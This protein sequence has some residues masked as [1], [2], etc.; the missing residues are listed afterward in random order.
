MNLLEDT[1]LN[2]NGNGTGM[3][4]GYYGFQRASA[5]ISYVY[6]SNSYIGARNLSYIGPAVNALGAVPEPATWAMM[7][8]GFVGIG[9]AVRRTARRNPDLLVA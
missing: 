1:P 8:L 6:F 2:N 7:L 4:S 3:Q 9:T 5:D